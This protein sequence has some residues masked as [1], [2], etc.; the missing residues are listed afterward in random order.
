MGS[1]KLIW[2]VKKVE[3]DLQFG[4]LNNEITMWN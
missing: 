4:K 3:W 2:V 1:L